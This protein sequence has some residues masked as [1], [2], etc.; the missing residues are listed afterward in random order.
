MLINSIALIA[1]LFYGYLE[2]R[3][4]KHLQMRDELQ[5]KTAPDTAM[6]QR[7]KGL[8]KDV[9]QKSQ[10]QQTSQFQK[11][12][13]RNFLLSIVSLLLTGLAQLFPVLYPLNIL[14]AIL[15]IYASRI[16]HINAFRVLKR[17]K[18]NVNALMTI[19]LTTLLLT[20][21]F[22]IASV[23]F[24]V[25]GV[26][27][28]ITDRIA[29]KTKQQFTRIFDQHPDYVSVLK[30]G[31]EVKMA[32]D[33]LQVDDRVI[34]HAGEMIPADGVITEG[35]AT[36]DQHLLTG[37]AQPIE[38]ATGD[39]VFSS[40]LMLSGKIQF[41]V[42][43][44]GADTTVAKIKDVLKETIEF[45]STV[46]LRGE[47]FSE[48]LVKPIIVASGIAY[49]LVGFPGALAVLNTH[50]KNKT[51]VLSPITMMNYL[52][53]ASQQ[54]ILVKD[55]QSLELLSKVDTLVFDKTGT[56]TEEQP[57]VANIHCCADWDENRLLSYAAAAE[58][59]QTHPL[60]R[61]ILQEATQRQLD[62]PT[63]VNSECHL[64]YGLM[65]EMDH[66]VFHIGSERFM[67]QE[68]IDIPENIQH[69]QQQAQEAGYSLV[70]LAV[71]KQ[72]AG[73]IEL[74][75][76]LRPGIKELIHSIKQKHNIK[77][78]YIISGDH[79]IPTQ[80]LAQELNIDHYF[81]E[82]L[83]QDKADKIKQ[84]QDQGCFV[85]YVGDGINDAIALKTAQVSVSMQGASTVATD[86]AQIIL[87]HSGLKQLSHLFDLAKSFNKNMNITFGILLLPSLI[88]LTGAFLF[89][90]DIVNTVFINMTGLALGLGNAVR[91]V[92]QY[93][94]AVK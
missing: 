59:K 53:I 4:T 86:T 61:A 32:F 24:I 30:E 67:R 43:K 17:G 13:Q 80:K 54:G 55:G 21:Q 25:I 71:D 15:L 34:V 52:N 5:Q 36:V 19:T 9:E 89:G 16:I 26:A 37:E 87:M 50:P 27:F 18:I 35:H 88:G 29:Y 62:I 84:L 56:L 38:K 48:R 81:A 85:C 65:V 20:Q 8:F 22:F 39:G 94:N 60:A 75:P 92:F 23:I 46:Q 28:S 12:T 10:A 14:A 63:S 1:I 90:F 77:H 78:T 11:D 44:A 7:M 33:E 42:Q 57:H 74:R 82:V 64:G 79:E 41:K 69:Q 70:M 2:L 45:K 51:M 47:T 6:S 3:K 49:P 31:E 58:Y 93:K 73:A 76:T 91:P 72:L 83:P 40:T 68:N 66:Q